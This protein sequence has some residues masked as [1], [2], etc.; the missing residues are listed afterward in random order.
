MKSPKPKLEDLYY[1]DGPF[2]NICGMSLEPEYMKYIDWKMKKC[3]RKS[4]DIN[5]DH[6]VPKCVFR[7]DWNTG[8]KEKCW[9][10][11]NLAITHRTCNTKK[12]SK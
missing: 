4:A 11:N 8:G 9:S 3:T 10:P 5:I 2:C 7:K 12:G 1:I 6:I